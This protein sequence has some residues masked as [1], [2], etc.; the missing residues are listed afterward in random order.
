MGRLL[1]DILGFF[2]GKNSR[3][4]AKESGEPSTVRRL[5]LLD[6]SKK[7]FF[8]ESLGSEKESVINPEAKPGP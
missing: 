3:Y 4:L 6:E 2:M 8:A 5:C 1:R 7:G